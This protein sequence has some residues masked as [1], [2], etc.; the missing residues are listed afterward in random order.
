MSGKYLAVG[1]NSKIISVWNVRKLD[2]LVL[3]I[4]HKTVSGEDKEVRSGG[5]YK[6]VGDG[7]YAEF[8]TRYVG[9]GWTIES[10]F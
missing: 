7:E 6:L 9:G 2:P 8:P 4:K 10:L 5:A 3:N 1:S